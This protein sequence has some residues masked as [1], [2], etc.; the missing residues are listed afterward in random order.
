MTENELESHILSDSS[1]YMRDQLND[2]RNA[3]T[4][5]SVVAQDESI[6]YLQSHIAFYKLT[7]NWKIMFSA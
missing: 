7:L 3:N 6:Y 4:F 1:K 5:E 2:T